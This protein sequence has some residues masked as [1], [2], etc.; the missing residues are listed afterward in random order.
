MKIK[1]SLSKNVS[2]EVTTNNKKA[3]INGLKKS[4]VRLSDSLY[5]KQGWINKWKINGWKTS[6]K[7]AVKNVELWK[8][9][10]EVALQHVIDWRCSRFTMRRLARKETKK[11]KYRNY[12]IRKA[13]REKLQVIKSPF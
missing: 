9:L 8:E 12:E 7:K 1:V 10:D 2:Q 4:L 3:V 5:V 6:N 13:L 11:L